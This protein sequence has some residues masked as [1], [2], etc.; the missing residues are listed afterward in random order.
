MRGPGFKVLCVLFTEEARMRATSLLTRSFQ[1]AIAAVLAAHAG[2]AAALEFQIGEDTLRVENLFTIG[3]SFRMQDPDP[4]LIGKSTLYK[5]N[6]PGSND[7]GLGGSGLC[8]RRVTQTADSGPSTTLNDNQYNRG[9]IFAGCSTTGDPDGGAGPQ[10]AGTTNTQYVAAP[11]SFSPNAD[12]G[13]LNF[14]KHDLVHAVAKL[15]TDFNYSA[16]DFNFFVRTV[17]FFDA[18]YTDF[19]EVHNDTTMQAGTSELPRSVERIVGIDYD[20]L[21]Y[22]IGRTFTLGER[23]VAVKV[24][25]QVL[26]WGES[27]LLALNSLNTINPPDARRLAIPGLDLKEAFRPIGMVTLGTDLIDSLSAEFFYT[28]DWKPIQIDPVGSFFS[29]SDTLGDGGYYAM[30]GFGKNPEDPGYVI[31]NPTADELLRYPTGRRGHYRPIDT[32]GN[33]PSADQPTGCTDTLGAL[34]ST[35]SRTVF[36]DYAEEKKREPDGGDYGVSL[37]MFLEDLNNGTEVAFYFANYDSRLPVVSTFAAL[38]SCLP[39][40]GNPATLAADCQLMG[41]GVPAGE[42]VIPVDTMRLMV[43]YPED[44]KLYGVSF[45]TTVG[46]FALSGEYAFREN[47]PIQIDTVDLTYTSL[48]PAFPATDIGTL[49]PGRR[50]A[51]PAF[52]TSY[53]GFACT[54][55]ADCIQPGQY[56]QGF[57]RF[58]VG[59]ANLTVLRL[60]GGDNPIGAS[61]MTLLLEMGMQQV[62]DMPSLSELQLEGT[63]SDTHI[64][65]GADGTGGI[66]PNDAAAPITNNTLRQNPTANKDYLGY[67]TSESYGYRF[68]NLNRWESA[69][70]GQINLETLAII[71]HDVKGTSPGI[72]TN[73]LDGRK[74]F[75]FG[76]RGD[77]LSTYVAE[78]RYTWYTGGGNHDGQR[79]RD[80]LFVTFGYQF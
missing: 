76:I 78:V 18:N 50:S 45:N 7:P 22:N 35:A 66:E 57:E 64:S 79:D 23:D 27:S 20:I 36:R 52:L 62:F 4:S 38:D 3:A 70:F 34:G 17:A 12:N 13:D 43:E 25:A 54:S 46:D 72:G 9:V 6:N 30:L 31:E 59:Q 11:G 2:S 80:N 40:N 42:E 47:L 21:D 65:G 74:Q 33:A 75:N 60:I 15:T 68:L 32:C 69:L 53:R 29:Q 41:V 61:Q 63:G 44:I 28:Y 10:P 1:A 8:F 51:F 55:D 49:V 37:K 77:Y 56:I 48:Q 67:G 19:T 5:I 26:N 71:R 14:E 73:F 58:K 39:D 16:Y 24:G